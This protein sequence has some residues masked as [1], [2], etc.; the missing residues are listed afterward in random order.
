LH[1]HRGSNVVAAVGVEQEI[2][3]QIASPRPIPQ[4]VMRIDD[5]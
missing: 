2:R 3:E 1:E 5:R 4:M